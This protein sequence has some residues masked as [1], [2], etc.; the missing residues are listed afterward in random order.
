M[1]GKRPP[2]QLVLVIVCAS[3]APS[4]S[5]P[6]ATAALPSA[7]T[8]TAPP[9]PAPTLTPPG[10]PPTEPQALN[11]IW[12]TYGGGWLVEIDEGAFQV[13]DLTSVSCLPAMDGHVEGNILILEDGSYMVGIVED[14]LVVAWNDTVAISANRLD[15]LPEACTSS[16]TQDSQDPEWNFEVLWHTFAEHYAFF[17]LH[18]V[19]WQAQDRRRSAR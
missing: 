11:G 8:T 6:M 18:Q 3:C 1:N 19:D 16:S 9:T 4:G 5:V 15:A 13:Y 12:R 7:T 17:E 10:V 2:A 14:K